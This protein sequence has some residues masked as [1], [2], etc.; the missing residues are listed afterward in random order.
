MNPL[1]QN[2][3]QFQG[4]DQGQSESQF[5]PTDEISQLH[6]D[7]LK[8]FHELWELECVSM[9]KAVSG[10]ELVTMF[11]KPRSEPLRI[12]LIKESEDY[13]Q[14]EDKE[15]HI[16]YD[17]AK[18]IKKIVKYEDCDIDEIESDINCIVE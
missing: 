2:C 12:N 3:F 16:Y 14:T 9:F 6:A 11:F 4:Q 5:N 17:F 7:A 8:K 15:W 1:N 18:L 13:F 10:K